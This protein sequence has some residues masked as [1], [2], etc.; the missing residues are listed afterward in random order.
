MAS[1][2]SVKP[3]HESWREEEEL[4]EEQRQ[5][6]KSIRRKEKVLSGMRNIC[7]T[8]ELVEEVTTR[9]TV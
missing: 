4:R 3:D 5:T 1:E 8:D 7:D 2:N 6:M 9:D